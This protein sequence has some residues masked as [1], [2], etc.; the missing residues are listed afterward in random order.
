MLQYV[1]YP[2]NIYL[3]SFTLSKILSYVVLYKFKIIHNKINAIVIVY[4]VK[5]AAKMCVNWILGKTVHQYYGA[6]SR[7][8]GIQSMA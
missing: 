5:P 4:N 8:K 3:Q 6:P 7:Q 1:I 2:Y